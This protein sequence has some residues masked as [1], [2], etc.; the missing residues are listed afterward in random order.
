[1]NNLLKKNDFATFLAYIAMFAIALLVGLLVISPTIKGSSLSTPEAVVIVVVSVIVGVIVNS[2]GLELLHMLGAASG[3]Y[4]ILSVCV[5]SMTFKKRKSRK[6][7][8]FTFASFEGLTGETKVNPKDPE[9]SNPTGMIL[10]PML[11]YLLEVIVLLVLAAVFQ[12][13][14]WVPVGS[15]VILAIGG[16][17]FVYN[18]IPAHL[19]S[20]TDGYLL[21]LLSRPVNRVAYNQILLAEHSENKEQ[22]LENLPL[23]NEISDFTATLNSLAA[24]RKI[25]E[26]KP[27]EALAIFSAIASAQKGVSKSV[28]QEASCQKLALLLLLEKKGEAKDYY[29]GMSDADRRY[30]ASLAS[31]PALRCYALISGILEES[32]SEVSWAF[33][34][35][36][37]LEKKVTGV[38]LEGEKILLNSSYSLLKKMH[39]G[40]DI[41]ADF[42][43]HQEEAK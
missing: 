29:E 31:L 24:Y 16:M 5:L 22:A 36:E 32:D 27:E 38:A 19:D 4:Q 23:Y 30:I 42:I 17:I 14:T 43:E 6:E 15:Y 12:S 41:Q 13:A 8:L 2:A 7:K 34:K 28:V 35:V 26:G 33:D 37:R 11:G 21:I 1:M 40:W 10:F 20:I 25:K 3:G 39:P 9:K 18:A